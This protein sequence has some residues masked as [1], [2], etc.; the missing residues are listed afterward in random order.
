VERWGER[1]EERRDRERRDRR[2]RERR[3]QAAL[4]IVSVLVRVL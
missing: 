4:F 2:E 1:N 3:G